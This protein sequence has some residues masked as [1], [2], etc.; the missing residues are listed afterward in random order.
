MRFWDPRRPRLPNGLPTWLGA[1]VALPHIHI[2]PVED[3][4][5]QLAHVGNWV[6]VEVI[7]NGR[8]VGVEVGSPDKLIELIRAWEEFP[9]GCLRNVFG[10]EP[11]MRQARSLV[12]DYDVRTEVVNSTAED[13]GL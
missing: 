8:W 10:A 7:V 2:T 6:F 11:P 9:E 3:W 1:N 13:L 4:D 5:P 12:Q